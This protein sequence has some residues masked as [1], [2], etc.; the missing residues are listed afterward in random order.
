[1]YSLIVLVL[2]SAATNGRV[3]SFSAL[4]KSS[5]AASR[6]LRVLICVSSFLSSFP[7]ERGA[8]LFRVWIVF[9][10]RKRVVL[11]VLANGKVTCAWHGGLGLGNVATEFLDFPHEFRHR[12][13]AHVSRDCLFG[14]HPLNQAT[15]GRCVRAASVDVLMLSRRRIGKWIDFPAEQ[16][17][18]E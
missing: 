12:R 8:S 3:N 11:G 9:P 5:R 2:L 4:G 13:H 1:M 7:S 16:R 18:V 6:S 10:N 14:T 15:V 17:G